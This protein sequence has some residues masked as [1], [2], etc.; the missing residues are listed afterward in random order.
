MLID[1][2]SEGFPSSRR[3]APLGQLQVT[4][5]D[6]LWAALTVGRPNRYYVFR[7]G[8]ASRLE[9]IF[10]LSLVRM[11]LEEHRSKLHS[12]SAF[13][14]L[15]PTEKGAVSYFL[16]MV[17]CKVFA[18]CLLNTPW[19]LHLDVFRDSLN[20]GALS[21]RSRPDLVGKETGS[22]V[23]HAFECKGRASTPGQI[24]K[25]KAKRQAVR[26]V[27]VQGTT[28]QLH[29][30]AITY[31]RNDA[32]HFY[33]CDPELSDPNKL[34]PIE[35]GLRNEE[36][37]GYYEPVGE[38]IRETSEKTITDG[39]GQRMPMIE[40]ADIEV[41]VHAE[42]APLL[43]ERRWREAH[44]LS[45]HMASALREQGFRPDGLI[46]KGGESWR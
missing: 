8:A 21:G 31:F 10:R 5:D 29:I 20:P 41:R 34:S 13:K 6:I 43:L 12:T 38:L 22:K 27:R 36:W 33:W 24:E 44:D 2:E 9:A 23:W 4:W 17:F 35:L 42:I 11:A 45:L 15:D 26:L 3:I 25:N 7:H 30:G 40:E 14:S 28:T 18:N 37:R 1:Y 16:G 19:L 46:V 32:L 39:I